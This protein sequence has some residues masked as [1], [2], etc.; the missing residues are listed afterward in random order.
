MVAGR[1]RYAVIEDFRA[2]FH[3]VLTRHHFLVDTD[4]LNVG[5]R[6]TKV[7]RLRTAYA[8]EDWD[9]RKTADDQ[10]GNYDGCDED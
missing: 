1:C 5:P 2:I 3:M 9:S 6:S 8:L 10:H 4:S 7:N